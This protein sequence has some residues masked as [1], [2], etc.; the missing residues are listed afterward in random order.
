ME[1]KEDGGTS[2][3][4]KIVG[5][6]IVIAIIFAWLDMVHMYQQ[7]AWVPYRFSELLDKWGLAKHVPQYNWIQEFIKLPLS[8]VSL[9]T[10]FIVWLF[11]GWKF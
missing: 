10:A 6:L 7:E 4:R 5:V 1:F 11:G 9:I 2:L 8:G 3:I